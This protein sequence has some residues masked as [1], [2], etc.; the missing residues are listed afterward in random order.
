MRPA[1]APAAAGVTPLG[2]ATDTLLHVS[3]CHALPDQVWLRELTLP[4]G[5]SVADAVAASGFA[6]EFQG[7]HA[8]TFGVGIYGK[9]VSP[10]RVLEAG[11]RVEVYRPL[12]FDPMES[13]RRRAGHRRAKQGKARV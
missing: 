9:L 1:A 3:V 11:D 6:R 2:A 10:E 12:V 7:V 13:R 5:S 8:G 4:A